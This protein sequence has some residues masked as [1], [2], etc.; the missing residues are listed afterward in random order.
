MKLQDV[1]N[2]VYPAHIRE[3]DLE[4]ETVREHLLK[5][6]ALCS[7]FLKPY[8]LEQTGYLLGILH[9]FGKVSKN[10]KEYLC[11]QYSD[12]P[13]S[14]IIDHSTCA[15]KFLWEEYKDTENSFVIE[16]LAMCI[17]SHH[18]GLAAYVNVNNESD[19]LRRL[20]EKKL[21]HYEEVKEIFFSTICSK[22]EIRELV[23]KSAEELDEVLCSIGLW[24]ADEA[25]SGRRIPARCLNDERCFMAGLWQKVLFSALIDADRLATSLFMSGKEMPEEAALSDICDSLIEKLEKKINSFTV[26]NNIDAARRKISDQCWER[27]AEPGRILRLT[28]P[29][30]SGKTLASMRFALRQAKLY[31]KSRI[32][33]VIPYTTIIEQ[34]ANEIRE[35]FVGDGEFNESILLEHHSNVARKD[36]IGEKSE[37]KDP[38]DEGRKLWNYMTERW[39]APLIFTTIVQFLNTFFAGGTRAIRKLH[40]IR[41]SVIIFDEPQMVPLKTIF[42]FNMMVNFLAEYMDCTIVLC[43]ATQP[44]LDSQETFAHAIQ[45]NR[46]KRMDLVDDVNS[47]FEIFKRCRLEDLTRDEA[48]NPQKLSGSQIAQ[49]LEEDRIRYQDVLCI[50]NTTAAARKIFAE[51]KS[52]CRDKNAKIFHLSTKMCAEHRREVITEIRA[53]LAHNRSVRETG[54]GECIPL[55]VISTQLIQA[56]VDVSFSIVYRSLAGLDDIAQAAGRC[57]RHGEMELGIVKIFDNGEENLA[58]LDDIRRGGEKFLTLL[59]NQQ[60]EGRPL[61]DLFSP[62]S[63]SV[64][65]HNYFEGMSASKYGYNVKK[66]GRKESLF[67]LL[68]TNRAHKEMLEEK[69]KEKGG[70]GFLNAQD[71]RTAGNEFAVIEEISRGVLVPY[72]KGEELAA[73]LNGGEPIKDW[74]AIFRSMQQYTVNLSVSE[75]KKIMKEEGIYWSWQGEIAI[76]KKD[77]YDEEK[78]VLLGGEELVKQTA[79]IV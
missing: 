29:T 67:D 33:S 65:F 14:Y 35:I 15:A 25:R 60:M 43:T 69:M 53:I 73:L 51:T 12:S 50:V 42:L 66:E 2:S 78:G 57:N 63:V 26:R 61:E 71:F 79:T 3:W 23:Q 19:F 36:E 27:G 16:W 72:G 17:M 77:F 44:I 13:S 58:S 1:N 56:G 7:R 64:Y 30:G 10:F 6:A 5:T 49:K 34:N 41:G 74:D 24:R 11:S 39:T 28:V 55:L 40:Q 8:G 54:S 20:I 32:I 37:E 4:V 46:Q 9:D 31:G 47:F 48:G 68:S 22:E 18:G 75:W 70:A 45:V 76:L 59:R 21:K 52:R 38:A 62:T